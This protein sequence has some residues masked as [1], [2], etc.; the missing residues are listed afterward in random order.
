V[1]SELKALTVDLRRWNDEVF[2]D[3]GRERKSSFWKM[4]VLSIPPKKR[5]H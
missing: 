4:Y 1:A 2:G 5:G 3:V